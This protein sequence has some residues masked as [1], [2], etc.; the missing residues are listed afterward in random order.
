MQQ[1]KNVKV[2]LARLQKARRAIEMHEEGGK[3][4]REWKTFLAY[5]DAEKA[6]RY[7][8]WDQYYADVKKS[9][10]YE[11]FMAQRKAFAENNHMR[12]RELANEIRG[13]YE[14]GEITKTPNFTDPW[15]LHNSG[16]VRTYRGIEKD[17]RSLLEQMESEET[18]ISDIFTQ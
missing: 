14:S 6:R 11:M 4:I 5:P 18:D 3:V 1:T 15:E 12:V 8:E 2:T 13:V 7:N 16:W 9:V 17:I 10:I